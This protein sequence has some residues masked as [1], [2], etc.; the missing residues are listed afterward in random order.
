MPSANPTLVNGTLAKPISISFG[1]SK[2]RPAAPKPAKKRPHA[3][4]ADESGSEDDSRGEPQSVVAF[5][6]SAGG[7]VTAHQVRPK[8]VLVIKAEKNRDWR[9]ESRKRRRKNL[10]PAEVQAQRNGHYQILTG[11]QVE[12]DEVSKTSGLQFVKQDAEGD[13]TMEMLASQASTIAQSTISRTADEEAMA[14]LLSNGE[15]KSTLTI[16]AQE[17]DPSNVYDPGSISGEEYQDENERFK[18]DLRSRPDVATLED[19]AAVPV[20]DFGVAMLRGMG[21][22]EG[23]KVGKQRAGEIASPVKQE[24]RIIERR[25]ALLGVGAT[26]VPGGLGEELGAWGKMAKG[27]RKTDVTYNPVV[28]RNS[29]TGE[30]LSE[31]ELKARVVEQS[32]RDKKRG[33]DDWRDRRDRNLKI[34]AE[35]KEERRNGRSEFVSLEGVDDREGRRSRDRAYNDRS[36]SKDRRRR[37]RS[38]S[39]ERRRDRSRSN[40]RRRRDKSPHN[41]HSRHKSS[42][43]HS[44]SREPN[45]KHSSSRGE[46][47]RSVERM[48]HQY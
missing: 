8:N 6:Q 42:E 17:S 13:T 11:P 15:R 31:D 4:L 18:A 19:Y 36:R 48:H 20:E 40:E 25:P 10:L 34:D 2:S 7:A 27:R 43:N 32:E 23:G 47:S 30:L 38:R 26:E 21:W 28:M 9:E 45:S 37:E 44:R 5:D 22:R 24:P 1:T 46:R 3:A 16:P 29:V 41:G 39:R 35:K 33:E 14:S 12:R